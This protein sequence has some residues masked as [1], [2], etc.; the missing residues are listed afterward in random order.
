MYMNIAKT[1]TPDPGQDTML[2]AQFRQNIYPYY[3]PFIPMDEQFRR[4]SDFLPE[5]RDYYWISNYGRLYNA[6]SGY[7]C[8][9][10]INEAGYTL[11][12]L[13]RTEEA[14]A[15]GRPRDSYIGAHIL[16]C[17]CFVGPKPGPKYQV[18]HRDFKRSN[19]YYQN[20]E[21][22]T[23]QENLD[24]SRAAGNYWNGNVYSSARYSEEQVRAICE[25]LQAGITDPPTIC[26]Q[27][28]GCEPNPGLYSLIRQIKSGKNWSQVSKDYEGIVD[29]EHRNFTNDNVIHVMCHY[30]KDH[31]ATAYTACLEEILAYGGL[32]LNQFT[33][34]ERRRFASALHQLRYKNAYRR[35]A[36]LYGIPRQ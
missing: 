2:H 5:Y 16:V 24:Y 9:P 19:N 13:R 28:F 8:T 1:N 27:V 3:Y 15:A 12:N 7:L 17:T 21:W 34:K 36:D 33:D 29:V 23:P 30:M 10:T 6:N 25:L 31:P 22:T 32:Y 35:I 20:L 18:N 14:M 26:M 11:F 4:V